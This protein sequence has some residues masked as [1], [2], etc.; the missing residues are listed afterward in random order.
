MQYRKFGKSGL[1]VSILGFGCMRLPV[2]PPEAEG[3]DSDVK[4]IDEPEAIKM[5]RYAI[6]NGVNYVDTAYLYHEGNSENLVA[7]ALRDGYREKVMLATKLPIWLVKCKE[8]FDK[9][10]DEQLAKLETEYLDVYLLHALDKSRW[11][12]VMELIY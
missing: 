3:K 4:S 6:D 12:K 7:K 2:N 9:F 5:I 8:D 1:D 11:N 10:L